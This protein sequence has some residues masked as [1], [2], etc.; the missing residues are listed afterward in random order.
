MVQEASTVSFLSFNKNDVCFSIW[1]MN[2]Q[3]KSNLHKN[4]AE[5]RRITE[6]RKNTGL[7]ETLDYSE[8]TFGSKIRMCKVVRGAP[9]H[10][11]KSQTGQIVLKDY[12]TSSRIVPKWW[13]ARHF[14][15][16]W[17]KS[18]YGWRKTW[19]GH[20]SECRNMAVVPRRQERSEMDRSVKLW[21]WRA[22]IL[23]YSDWG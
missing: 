10:Q 15:F 17:A 19:P 9:L 4:C 18:A 12:R 23:F 13:T 2:A 6:I 3:S 21:I 5:E 1:K 20:I 8:S 16:K 14:L 7:W 22:M 11:R